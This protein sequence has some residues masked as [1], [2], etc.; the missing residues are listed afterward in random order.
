MRK[1][2]NVLLVCIIALE[3][4]NCS[5]INAPAKSIYF[6]YK[7]FNVVGFTKTQNSELSYPPEKNI[8]VFDSMK[9]WAKFINKYLKV[10][11][12]IKVDF[13]SKKVICILVNWPDKTTGPTYMISDITVSNKNLNI[14][15]RI[16]DLV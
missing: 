7:Y 1:I 5:Y 3:F 10:L 6:D 16:T 11:K 9:E 15:M 13:T 2:K 14:Y 4:M 12:P 8:Y